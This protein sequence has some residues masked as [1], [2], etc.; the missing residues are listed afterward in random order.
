MRQL[1]LIEGVSGVGKSTVAGKLCD[2]LNHRGYLSVCHLEGDADNPVD[3]F[4]CAYLTKEEFSR[5]LQD[6]PND[7]GLL[8]KNSIHTADYVLV[9]YRNRNVS[10]FVPPLLETLKAR[11]GFYKPAKSITME[12]YTKVFADCWRRYVSEDHGKDYAI[13]DGSFLYHRANDLINNYNATDEMIADHLESLLLAMLPYQPLLFY[14]SSENVGERLIKARKS[15]GQAP[16]TKARIG[17]EIERKNRQM[18]ILELLTIQAHVLEISD[19]NWAKTLDEMIEI[20]SE[21]GAHT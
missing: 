17:F 19:G 20:A 7:A 8:M 1:I 2:D 10:Y 4:G 15:R 3:L 9:H 14:L 13:F 5:F 18:K 12:Q 11:E 16:A 21:E 6:F